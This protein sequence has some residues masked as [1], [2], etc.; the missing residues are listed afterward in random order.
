MMVP[1]RLSFSGRRLQLVAAVLMALS[2]SSA[3]REE[4]GAVKVAS[5]SFEGNDTFDD[6]T[7]KDVIVTEAP[8]MLGI[9][10]WARSRYFNRD[11]FQADL[12]RLR[13]FYRD[14]GFPSA[15]VDGLDVTFNDRRDAVRIRIAV[16]EGTPVVVERID[17]TGL[18]TVGADV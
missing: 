4:D 15:A 16:T 9:L 13:A 1:L 2:V 3:C 5:I 12:E 7:L 10:P 6:G 11:A 17:V 14:R 18:E 8:G